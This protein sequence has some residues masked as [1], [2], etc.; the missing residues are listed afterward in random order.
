MA[1]TLVK[2]FADDCPVCF[3]L[4]K[5]DS[6]IAKQS[7]MEFEV[8]RLQHLK[9]LNGDGPSNLYSYVKGVC[10][11]D[12][13]MI[14]IPVYLIMDGPLIKAS[15]VCKEAEEIT[16]LIGA[17]ECYKNAQSSEDATT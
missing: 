1:E 14:N 8:I 3:E 13:G 11:D 5:V 2:I 6:D 9:P 15:G 12:D 4:S 10:V 7:K 17:W 16:N